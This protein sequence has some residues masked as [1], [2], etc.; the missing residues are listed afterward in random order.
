MLYADFGEY[1]FYEL[2]RTNLHL[3]FCCH[4][5]LPANESLAS[6][7]RASILSGL[8]CTLLRYKPAAL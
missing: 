4:Q 6:L 5:T 3:R 2:R 8:L 1:T 7:R